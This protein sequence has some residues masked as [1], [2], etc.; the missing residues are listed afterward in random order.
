MSLTLQRAYYRI[1]PLLIKKKRE[2][3]TK[4]SV[5]KGRKFPRIEEFF[6]IYKPLLRIHARRYR[7]IYVKS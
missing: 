2:E 7:K 4:V 1:S 3:I 5:Y 6:W